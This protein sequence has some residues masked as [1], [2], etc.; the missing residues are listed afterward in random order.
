MGERDFYLA[1]S[2]VGGIGPKT[3]KYLLNYSNTAKKA[4]ESTS[5]ELIN[6][7]LGEKAAEK[8][9]KNREKLNLQEFRRKLSLQK[10]DFICLADKEYPVLL[11]QIPDPPFLLFVKGNKKVFQNSQ[12]I[13]IVGTR[14]MTNYGR[15][16]TEKFAFDLA[17]A[18]ITVVS[19]MALGVDA[20]A[21]NATLSAGGKTVAVLGNGVDLPFPASNASI[22]YKIIE[23]GGAIISEFAPGTPPNKGTFPR[24]NRIIAGISQGILVT[25]GAEDSGSLITANYGLEFKRKVFAVPGPITSQ[26][27]AAPLRLIEKG[28]KLVVLPEDILK[29]F[30]VEKSEIKSENQKFKT[31]SKDELKIV[32]LIENEALSFDE[33]VRKLSS[34][35]SETATTLSVLELKGIVR[36]SGGNYSLV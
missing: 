7:G 14:K 21:H 11:K 17:Q 27:S 3:F 12:I 8:F 22:Y 28:A 35:S 5:K 24:R 25:E 1:F 10:I 34:K 6:A 36:N 30:K 18:G 2:V 32:Q 33:I 29:E 15:E 26:L 4:W 31:L 19:G 16:I 9:L 13:S 23:S 20:A